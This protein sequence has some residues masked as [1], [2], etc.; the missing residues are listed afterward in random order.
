MKP[1]K[2]PGLLREAF[3]ESQTI[4]ELATIF[5]FGIAATASLAFLQPEAFSAVPSWRTALALLLIFDVASGCIANFTRSTNV[6]Y[7]GRF[8]ARWT[9]IAIH[10][11][12]P[13]VALLLGVDSVAALVIWA[14]TILGTALVNGLARSPFQPFLGGTLLAIGLFATPLMGLSLPI[15][16]VAQLFLLKVLYGFA[17]DHFPCIDREKNAP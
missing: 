15:L 4:L 11:H 5:G 1:I 12:L 10:V 3:G 6:Y 16:I 9:F 2:I 17:V 8:G 14:Y 13:L 7:A